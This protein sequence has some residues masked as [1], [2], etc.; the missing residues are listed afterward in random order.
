MHYK[1]AAAIKKIASRI[2]E[3][4]LRKVAASDDR[5]EGIGEA[6]TNRDSGPGHLLDHGSYHHDLANSYIRQL[7]HN[8]SIDK[9]HY[10]H[11]GNYILDNSFANFRTDHRGEPVLPVFYREDGGMMRHSDLLK[12]REKQADDALKYNLNYDKD[13]AQYNTTRRALIEAGKRN[14]AAFDSGDLEAKNVKYDDLVPKNVKDPK[15]REHLLRQMRVMA[16]NNG[17]GGNTAI[18]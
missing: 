18:G 2:T 16:R 14:R 8:G 10:N 13:T 9:R 6:T 17:R 12:A 7:L 5:V 4:F 3:N 11:W 15:Q 1:T